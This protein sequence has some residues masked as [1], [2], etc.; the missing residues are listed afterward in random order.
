MRL[1]ELY[2]ILSRAGAEALAFSVLIAE[3]DETPGDDV[4]VLLSEIG[5]VEIDDI[6]GEAKLYP[7]SAVSEATPDQN[8]FSLERLLER[9]PSDVSEYMGATAD[10]RILVE[11]PLVRDGVGLLSKALV[12]VCDVHVSHEIAE[13]WLLVKPK[14]EYPRD[15]LLA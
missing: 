9:L 10:A 11:L 7:R 5:W 6:A 1:S 14:A 15:Q 13:A 4:D 8:L 3:P 12:E 2:A